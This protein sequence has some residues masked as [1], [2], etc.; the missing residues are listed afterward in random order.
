M[1]RPRKAN[2]L[3]LPPRVYWKHGQFWYEH[4]GSRKWEAL[5][6]DVQAAKKRAAVLSGQTSSDTMPHFLD[7]FLLAMRTWTDY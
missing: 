7:E 2:P 3:N 1:G 5:G 6:T 4:K